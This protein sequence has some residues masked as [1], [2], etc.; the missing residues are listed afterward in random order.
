MTWNQIYYFQEHVSQMSSCWCLKWYNLDT[1]II[2]MMMNAKTEYNMT[3]YLIPNRITVM[4]EQLKRLH[5][6]MPDRINPQN[7]ND[8]CDCTYGS[9]VNNIHNSWFFCTGICWMG[10][11]HSR[12]R[13]VWDWWSSQTQRKWWQ[14]GDG[15]LKNVSDMKQGLP[16]QWVHLNTDIKRNQGL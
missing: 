9:R 1:I 14:A 13:P 4:T 11:V 3:H 15:R 5:L 6:D 2:N 16:L 8:Q 12:A 7:V 10:E